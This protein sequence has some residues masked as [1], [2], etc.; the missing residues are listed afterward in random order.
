M[1]EESEIVVAALADRM[2][3]GL[4]KSEASSS[5]ALV[6]SIAAIASIIRSGAMTIDEATR[7]IDDIFSRL[8]LE[9]RNDAA[10]ARVEQATEWLR[11]SLPGPEFRGKTIEGSAKPTK[12][13]R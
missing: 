8:P 1:S 5:A 2:F 7:Q 9:H 11:A 3:Q 13:A 6:F 10:A 12:R 4:A